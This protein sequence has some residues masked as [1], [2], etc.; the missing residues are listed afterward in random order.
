MKITG[1][2]CYD[3][4]MNQHEHLFQIE[5]NTWACFG[6]ADACGLRAPACFTPVESAVTSKGMIDLILN[7][8][9]TNP[10]NV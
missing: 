9:D 2:L 4:V 6:H 10:W 3:G 8:L 1:N 5:G 7:D